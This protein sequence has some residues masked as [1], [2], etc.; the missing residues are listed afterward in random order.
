M[1]MNDAF[2]QVLTAPCYRQNK[3]RQ[4]GELVAG[5]AAAFSA[6]W[7]ATNVVRG[8]Y[9]CLIRGY[10][11]AASLNIDKANNNKTILQQY[12]FIIGTAR[13]YHQGHT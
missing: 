2:V 6:G 10:I 11:M 4:E 1:S 3:A 9:H 7:M 13:K 5:T 12:K 8:W